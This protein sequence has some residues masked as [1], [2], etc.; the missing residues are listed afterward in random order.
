MDMIKVGINGYGTIGRRV[1]HAVMLQKDMTVSGIVKTKPDYVAHFASRDFKVFTPDTSSFAAFEDGGLKPAGSLSDLISDSDIIVD[2]TPEKTGEKNVGLYR[3]A[4]IKAIFQGGEKSTIA[5]TSFS[6]YANY[7]QSIGRDYVRVVSCN[8]TGLARTLSA[9]RD[10]F[11]VNNVYV[12]LI[13]RGTDPNDH[14]KG[15]I[16]SLEPSMKIPSHHAPDLQTV[17]GDINVDTV[18]IKAPTTL[19][20]VHV[21][22][23]EL[24]K[25][26]SSEEIREAF[27]RYPRILQVSGNEGVSSTAQ[28]MDLARERGRDRSDLYEIALWKESINPR[29]NRINYIQAVHQESDV[30]PENVDAIRA[31][32]E[33]ADKE[34]SLSAT[35]A[36]LGIGN[37]VY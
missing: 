29:G 15:P 2:A 20:H 8:T 12:T 17:L 16:N 11:G 28:V 37:K 6:S 35:D 25:E 21:V 32:F 27:S 5:E 23:A 30:V 26:A 1:A 22:Q 9:L 19:M 7:D 31:M 3:K 36:S 4:G 33:L 24:G 14:K 10:N 13:R 18:A 34:K